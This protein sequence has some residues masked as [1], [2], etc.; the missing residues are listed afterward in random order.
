KLVGNGDC[1]RR[2]IA[3][4]ARGPRGAGIPLADGVP[5]FTDR[6]G[7]VPG[8]EAGF[9]GARISAAAA[10]IS[11]SHP[12]DCVRASDTFVATARFG[13]CRGS[14]E[15]GWSSSAAG[16]QYFG[17]RE[18]TDFGGG[19]VQRDTVIA[20][21]SVFVLGLRIF[22]RPASERAMDFAGGIGSGG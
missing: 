3:N 18:G 1:H 16:W 13:S 19:G 11:V 14:A 17:A 15:W 4:A 8:R 2:R 12:G 21:A 9:A 7:F 10:L 22:F 20:V 5:G 6:S